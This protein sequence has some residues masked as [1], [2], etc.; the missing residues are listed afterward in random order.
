MK[1][2]FLILCLLF[3]SGCALTGNEKVVQEEKKE[4]QNIQE[5]VKYV[6]DNKIKLG[7]FPASNNYNN[8]SVITDTYYTDFISGVD[9]GSF[10]VF[11]T[12]EKVVNG[13][14]FKDVWNTYYNKYEN[15]ESYKIGYNIKFIL[16]DGT[17]Y[18]GNFLTPNIFKFSEFFYVY[19]YD[20]IN[21]PDGAFY[22]HLEEVNDNTMIT[23][24]KIYAVSGIDK[25][26]NFILTAF[27]YDDDDFDENGNYRG[28]SINGIRI[29]RK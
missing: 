19:L 24:I 6:D 16:K 9:I 10:E 25:V 22:S 12:D 7:I 3:V 26:E 17:I 20:D 21:Q 11:L 23:S 2:I 4:E 1:K 29:K 5:E 13:T 15:I 18:E 28:N 14:S 27:T 8:K